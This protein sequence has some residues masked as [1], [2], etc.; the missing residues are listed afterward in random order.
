MEALLLTPGRADDLIGQPARIGREEG[1][2]RERRQKG[3][4][5]YAA[6]IADEHEADER[7]D[8]HR[9]VRREREV[10]DALALARG[11]QHERSHRRRSRRRE[12]E[13]AAVQEAQRIDGLLGVQPVEGEHDEEERDRCGTHQAL[14]V[15]SIDD[16]PGQRA[17]AHRTD[18]EGRHREARLHVTAAE[19][20][21]DEY[22]QRSHHDV[23][24]HEQE[25]VAPSHP[26]EFRRP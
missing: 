22:R 20:L 5:R 14:L 26:Q 15:D 13:D 25:E 24:G 18:L 1:Q 6:E 16:A 10:A 4:Q 7:A 23:L 9:E 21:H 11:R 17:A 8:D 12:R 19:R 2:R 3:K